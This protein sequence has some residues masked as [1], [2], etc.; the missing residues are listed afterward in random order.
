MKYVIIAID[1]KDETC[2][3]CHLFDEYDC[4]FL[5][6]SESV[7]RGFWMQGHRLPGC[8]AV[9]A[10]REEYVKLFHGASSHYI[11]KTKEPLD[12]FGDVVGNQ[13]AK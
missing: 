11:P 12:Y 9:E 10:Y 4:P 5:R 8:I 13:D 1:A 7:D 3:D 6:A 2:G